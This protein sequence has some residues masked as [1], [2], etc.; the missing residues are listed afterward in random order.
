MNRRAFAIS[1]SLWCAFCGAATSNALRTPT[2]TPAGPI[3]LV[4]VW[5]ASRC[6]D[7][8]IPDAPLRAFRVAPTSVVGFSTHFKNRR[9]LGA[10]LNSIARDCAV[11]FA[12]RELPNPEDYSDRVWISSTWSEDGHTIFALGH[13]EYQANCHPGRC[14]FSTYMECWYNAIVLL[15]SD[16]GGA[17][18]RAWGSGPSPQFPSAR[19]SIRATIAGISSQAT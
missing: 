6:A 4:F 8:D 15:R 17:A 3:E 11:V 16:D 7:D 18:F 5:T 10:D 9:F 14:H 13:D 19:T 2:L 12:G 1:L